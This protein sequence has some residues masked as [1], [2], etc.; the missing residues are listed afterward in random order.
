MGPQY[1]RSILNET[2][3]TYSPYDLDCRP[4][5]CFFPHIQPLHLFSPVPMPISATKCKELK[6]SSVNILHPCQYN[7]QKSRSYLA[8]SMAFTAIMASQDY[9]MRKTEF[10]CFAIFSK[11]SLRD[12]LSLFLSPHERARKKKE[13]DMQPYLEGK[14]GAGGGRGVIIDN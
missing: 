2:D 14:G 1:N 3:S 12:A 6:L 4:T 8:P 5:R 10:F 7:A 13:N 11:D 9:R